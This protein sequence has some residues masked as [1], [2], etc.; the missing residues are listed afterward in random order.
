[1]SSYF[2]DASTCYTSNTTLT[3]GSN[4]TTTKTE[5]DLLS[6][7]EISDSSIGCFQC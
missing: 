7:F 3:D 4:T 2:Q 5:I 6:E 1:M